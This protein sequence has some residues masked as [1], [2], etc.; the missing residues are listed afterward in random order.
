MLEP[1]LECACCGELTAFSELPSDA[2]RSIV[3]GN[4]VET[5]RTA[6]VSFA[7]AY[8]QIIL[9]EREVGKGGLK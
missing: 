8:A 4:V 9:D 6:D 1:H 2:L 3:S 5:N 7:V